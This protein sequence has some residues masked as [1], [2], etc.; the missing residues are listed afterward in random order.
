M[1]VRIE[2]CDGSPLE[3]L[4]SLVGLLLSRKGYWD[5]HKDLC[6]SWEGKLLF[7]DSNM[8]LLAGQGGLSQR[9]GGPCQ[10][11]RGSGG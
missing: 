9:G 2:A 5:L 7:K 1:V 8:P 3:S 10:G 4:Q 6:E 11:L